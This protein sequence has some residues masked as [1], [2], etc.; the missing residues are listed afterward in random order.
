M[1]VFFRSS[2]VKQTMDVGIVR[3]QKRLD[4]LEH[5]SEGR[6]IMAPNESTTE[7]VTKK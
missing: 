6:N 3:T 7:L 5:C 4:L 2:L 1:V